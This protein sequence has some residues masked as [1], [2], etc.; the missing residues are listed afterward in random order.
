MGH[1]GS[2]QED[3]GLAPPPYST[4]FAAVAG[5]PPSHHPPLPQH[6]PPPDAQHPSP[7]NLGQP[8]AEAHPQQQHGVACQPYA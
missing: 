4:S 3:Q 8:E 6:Q 5:H 2:H 7:C 1:R